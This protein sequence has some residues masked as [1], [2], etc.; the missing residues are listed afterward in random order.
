MR[1]KVFNVSEGVIVE[2]SEMLEENDLVG[3]ITGVTE[4]SE[5]QISVD[6]EREN[7]DVILDLMELVDGTG[8][9]DEE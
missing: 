7:R 6:Y 2:F 1:T 5:I 8:E 9:E 4:D 3:T